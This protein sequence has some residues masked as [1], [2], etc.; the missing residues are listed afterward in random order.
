MRL[1]NSR[2][3]AWAKVHAFGST[4]ADVSCVEAPQPDAQDA[5]EKQLMAVLGGLET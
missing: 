1:P 3:I 5:V 4:A 2:D